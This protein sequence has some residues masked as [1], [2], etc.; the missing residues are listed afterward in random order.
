MEKNLNNN[1]CERLLGL[2]RADKDIQQEN[3][4]QLRKDGDIQHFL[5][6]QK[7][8]E[9]AFREGINEIMGD[10]FGEELLNTN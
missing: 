9:Q 1:V 8:A 5:A 2:N 3:L 6:L 10:E 4:A 7:M